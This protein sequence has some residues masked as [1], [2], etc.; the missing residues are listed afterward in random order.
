MTID[1]RTPFTLVNKS[2]PEQFCRV[3]PT[4]DPDFLFVRFQGAC[5]N[6]MEN[7]VPAKQ[8]M[9]TLAGL[10]AAGWVEEVLSTSGEEAEPEGSEQKLLHDL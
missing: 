5:G 1:A 4:D 9:E 3:E 7:L 6:I 2:K 10:Y 8:V